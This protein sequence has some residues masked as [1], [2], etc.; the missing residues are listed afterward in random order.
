VYPSILARNAQLKQ[1][2][3]ALAADA[4]VIRREVH[5]ELKTG[6]AST[7][8]PQ[9]RAARL[10]DLAAALRDSMKLGRFAGRVGVEVG[11]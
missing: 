4:E 2:A 1:W 6:A 5:A 7:L 9:Q 11:Q 10:G 8:D 3:E